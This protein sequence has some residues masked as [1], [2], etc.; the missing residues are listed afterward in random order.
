MRVEGFGLRVEGFGLGFEGAHEP[1]RLCASNTYRIVRSNLGSWDTCW[2][3]VS[4]LGYFWGDSWDIDNLLEKRS[5][6][7]PNLSFMY[8]SSRGTTVK[9][10]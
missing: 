10:R 9:K 2:R 6:S 3:T 8:F 5:Y 1:K 7:F 4:Q